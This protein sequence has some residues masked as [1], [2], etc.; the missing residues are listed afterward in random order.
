[1]G[2]E[3]SRPVGVNPCDHYFS[4]GPSTNG[5]TG[6]GEKAHGDQRPLRIAGEEAK[7]KDGVPQH[8]YARHT[9]N[10][11]YENSESSIGNS[12]T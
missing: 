10:G 8:I 4:H 7:F 12:G 9:T 11:P 5:P 2:G 3:N 1:M 6:G